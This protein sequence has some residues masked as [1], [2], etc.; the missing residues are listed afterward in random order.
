MSKI[1]DSLL[2]TIQQAAIPIHCKAIPSAPFEKSP[3]ASDYDALLQ[4][5]GP[6]TKVVM[7]G[8]ASHGTEEF[9]RHRAE[10]TKRLIK[11]LGFNVVAVEADWPD[12]YRVN[13]YVRGSGTSDKS[14]R[15]ALSDFQRFPRWM[16]RN[17]VV[18]EFVEWMK[19]YN[20]ELE[21][22]KQQQSQGA[23]HQIKDKKV[24]FYGLDMYSFQ[25]SRN[26]VLNYLDKVDPEAARRARSY[27]ACFDQYG[28]DDLGSNYSWAVGLNLSRSCK[29]SC[30]KALRELLQRGSELMQR[31]SASEEP[32]GRKRDRLFFAQQNAKVVKD[33]EEY[34]R[35]M[36]AGSH[37]TWNIRDSH[38]CN[39][40][41]DLMD[42]LHSQDGGSISEPKAVIWAHNSH[43]GDASQTDAGWDDD[44]RRFRGGKEVN[45]GQL[46]RQRWGMDRCFNIGFSTYTGT[47]TAA[48]DW[49]EEP[50]FYKVNESL[51]DSWEYVL[52]RSGEDMGLSD[53]QLLFRANGK[54][55]AEQQARRIA[56]VQELNSMNP[57]V[58]RAIG[59]VYRPKTERQSHYFGARMARQFDAMI[60]IDTTSALQPLDIRQG[61]AGMMDETFPFGL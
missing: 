50:K 31:D 32:N 9:Y 61:E 36:L 21:K 56:L 29:E 3:T 7:I 19:S 10:I 15:E 23:Q 13:R 8:E 6:D 30:E 52:H 28:G 42:F 58:Q 2:R 43:L 46:V 34:Y 33:A 54:L 48:H 25:A 4:A 39:T 41:A 12:A 49:D 17:T 55:D 60:H 24:G 57:R 59:V 27:Y 35:N 20:Q 53:Y 44:K 1:K 47:V 11:E 18:E 40:L 45:L 26:A 37:V 51:K 5:I 22:Q 14:P 38:M 16:W